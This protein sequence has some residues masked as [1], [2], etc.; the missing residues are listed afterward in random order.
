MG[1]KTASQNNMWLS[2]CLCYLFFFPSINNSLNEFFQVGLGLSVKFLTPVTYIFGALIGGLSYF[3]LRKR[4]AALSLLIVCFFA[5]IAVSYCI[6]PEIRH[7]IYGR[8]VDLVYNPTNKILFYCIPAFLLSLSVTDF[9]NLY[10][11][12]LFWS[13]LALI[14]GVFSYFYVVLYKYGIMQYMVYSYFMITSVCACFENFIQKRK[15]I[16]LLLAL[17]GSVSMFFCGARGA[18]V[19]LGMFVILRFFIFYPTKNMQK[20]VL[21]VCMLFVC[22][23]LFLVFWN[24]ILS[25]ATRVCDFFGVDSRFIS[26]ILD[27][28]FFQ[29]SGRKELYAGVLDAIKN[30]PWGY[31]LFGDRYVAGQGEYG[32]YTY[33]HNILLEVLCDFGIFGV[34]I[35]LFAFICFVRTMAKNQD[36]YFHSVIWILLPYALFQLIFSSSFLENVLFY[37]VVGLIYSNRKMRKQNN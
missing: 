18:I 27:G 4:S 1:N 13:R 12:A 31:G 17:I 36:P 7:L 8:F 3:K 15:W 2:F 10:K 23:I 6:Y 20:K 9:C 26:R 11:V 25:Y 19:A 28:T 14:V 16:D 33:I 5:A 24:P 29:G 30:K 32:K 34:L 37:A 21:L 35:I 22:G